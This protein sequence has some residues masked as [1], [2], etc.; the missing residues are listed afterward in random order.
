MRLLAITLIALLAPFALAQPQPQPATRPA[1]D[2]QAKAIIERSS[3]LLAST[4]QFIFSAHT[5]SERLL[6]DGQKVQLA[7]NERITVQ[8]P[9]KLAAIVV[10]DREN[11]RFWYDGSVVGLYN[12]REKLVST[13]DAPNTIDATLDALATK[14]GMSLPLSDLVMSDPHKAMCEHVQSALY[15]GTGYVFD[16]VCHHLAFRQDGIDWELWVDAGERAVP[17]KLVIH[18]RDEPQAPEYTAFLT[19]WDLAPKLPDDAFASPAPKDAK[20]VPFAAAPGTPPTS[21]AK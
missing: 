5:T 18:Y 10:G 16:A 2:P 21:V 4:K 9:N 7:Q 12:V 6:R 11:F 19:E 15:L 8:R 1:I 14:H 13:T 17:R 20:S 3:Q